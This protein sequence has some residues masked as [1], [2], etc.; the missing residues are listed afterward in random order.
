MA[1]LTDPELNFGADPLHA[2]IL[3]APELLREAV[4]DLPADPPSFLASRQAAAELRAR[5]PEADWT[6]I[7]QEF[8]SRLKMAERFFEHER[9]TGE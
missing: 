9:K 4:A 1:L 5:L 7:A 6:L 2:E 3:E 8:R